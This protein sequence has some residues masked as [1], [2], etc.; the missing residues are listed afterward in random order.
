MKIKKATTVEEQIDILKN[1]NMIIEDE[2]SAKNF[3]LNINYYRFTGYTYLFRNSDDT[4]EQNITFNEI[5]KI[6]KADKNLRIILFKYISIIEIEFKTHIAYELSNAI[7]TETYLY[8]SDDLYFNKEHFEQFKENLNINKEK[9]KD[10][11]FIKHYNEKYNGILPLWVATEIISLGDI[12]RFYNNLKSKYAQLISKYY[13]NIND[14][15]LKSWFFTI[16]SIRNSCAH[17]NRLYKTHLKA[18]P[19]NHGSLNFKRDIS[20]AIIIIGVLLRKDDRRKYIEEINDFIENNR[21]TLFSAKSAY[22]L[23]KKKYINAINSIT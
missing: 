18:V 15:T 17:H 4:F 6:Y 7:Q 11:L 16:S 5:K 2:E 3:L 10:K 20:S 8:Y 9:S 1:R 19:K 14:D 23:D 12:S 22:G 21:G 13:Y